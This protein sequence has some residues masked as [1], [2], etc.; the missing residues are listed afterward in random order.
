MAITYDPK[1]MLA[2]IAPEKKVKRLIS[3]KVGLKKTALSFVKDIDF[4]DQAR[5][6]EVAL[7]T[8]KAYR[9]RV[10]AA[11]ESAK[12]LSL[13]KLKSVTEE[14]E[15]IVDDPRLLIQR[16]QNDVVTQ[17]SQGIRE[18]YSGEQYEWLPSDADEPDPEHQL[19]YGQ[20]FTIG[21][22]EQPGDRYGCRCGMRIL[23][24]ET[25][26]DLG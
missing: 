7:K 12:D 23:V 24:N 21:E 20:I 26:L 19:N 16:V 22:G 18:T 15:G 8:I 3:D 13:E 25:Q 11:Q 10:R 9:D 6:G 5:I 14:L 2:K 1:K 4:I 17:V